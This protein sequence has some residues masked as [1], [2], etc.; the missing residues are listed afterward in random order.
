MLNNFINPQGWQFPSDILFLLLA[1]GINIQGI[2]CNPSCH[3][4]M[5]WKSD[6]QGVFSTK[7]VYE[8]LR[9]KEDSSWRWKY[10]WRQAIHPRL[11]GF[12]WRLLNHILPMDD[13]I[14][15][16]GIS[17]VSVCH[18]CHNISELES[19]TLLRCPFAVSLW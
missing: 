7:N 17:I 2:Q 4:T 6:I 9:S 11:G 3:D 13:A 15:K 1:L 18:Q 8:T 5:I 19:H 14:M 12:A 10:V 16:R